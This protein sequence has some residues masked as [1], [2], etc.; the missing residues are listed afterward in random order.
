MI[1]RFIA[2]CSLLLLLVGCFEYDEIVYQGAENL[3]IGKLKEGKTTIGLNVTLDNPNNYNVKIKPSTLTVFLGNKE[4]GEVYLKE[5]VVIQKKSSQSYPLLLEAKLKD[6]LK[7][8]LVGLVEL[9]TKKTVTIRLQGYVRGSV[10]GITQ[11][12]YV[13]QT[14]EIETAQFIKLFGL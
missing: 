9:A 10:R 2:I 8:G 5:R 13:D 14:K 1:I 11:K 12:R 7:S 3:K 4:L 6:V